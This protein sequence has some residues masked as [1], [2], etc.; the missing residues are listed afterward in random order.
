MPKID[1]PEWAEKPGGINAITGEDHGP[2]AEIVLGDAA[3]LS[4]FG[5][6]M[7]RL[8]P[9]SRSSVRHWHENEDE[10]IYVIFGQLVLVEDSE[11][12][13]NAGDAAGWSAGTPIAHCLENRSADPAIILIVGTRASEEVV[14]YPDHDAVLHRDATGVRLT[15]PDGSPFKRKA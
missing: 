15:T 12:V 4:Q 8:A 3:G 1:I 13:L 9:G 11:T 2:Y 10:F 7:E 6:R 5:V 14:H